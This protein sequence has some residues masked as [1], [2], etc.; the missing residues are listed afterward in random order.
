MNMKVQIIETAESDGNW[1]KVCL[2]GFCQVAFKKDRIDRSNEDAL[3][4]A[5]RVFN[6]ILEHGKNEKVIKEI[7][8]L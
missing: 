7:E 2:N 3:H 4:E 5:E 6:F 8:I 1:Y